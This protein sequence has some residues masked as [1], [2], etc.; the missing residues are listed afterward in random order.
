[1]NK[2][3][4]FLKKYP[5]IYKIAQT[6]FWVFIEKR[7]K[8]LGS[9]VKENYWEKRHLLKK[10]DWQKG[11]DWIEKYWSSR[12]HPHRQILV[13]KIAYYKPESI[14]EIGSNC[15]PNLYLLSQKFPKVEIV[16]IDINKESIKRGKELFSQEGIINVRLLVAKADEI[17]QFS[18]KSFDIVFTDAVLMYIG[19]DKIK[20]VALEIQRIAKKAIILV[21][22]HSEEESALGVYNK[23]NWL[24]DYKELFQSFSSQVK[25]YKISPKIWGGNWGKLGYI[26]EV[27]P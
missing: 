17:E 15:G 4:L 24:R 3:K 27:K 7:E 25:T 16:G 23:G 6:I 8:L 14:L 9:K 1:M 12:A 10:G 26:I 11:K 19:P 18:D 5:Q 13:E 20:K 2:I 21:E 22:H